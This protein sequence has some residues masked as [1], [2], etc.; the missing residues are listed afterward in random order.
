MNKLA[1][2]PTVNYI[3]L[4]E[5][6]DRRKKLESHFNQYDIKYV[7]H[8]FDRVENLEKYNF[9]HTFPNMVEP[10]FIS[11]FTVLR[12]W[13]FN[14]EDEYTVI[15]EDDL[16]LDSVRYWNF[17]W[18][19]FVE[20]LPSNWQCLQMV[21]LRHAHKWETPYNYKFT[22]REP[23][24]RGH[25][26][27]CAYLIKREYVE[28]LI[29]K[30][31]QYPHKFTLELDIPLE[32]DLEQVLFF[33]IHRRVYVFPLFVEDCYGLNTT[34]KSK[35]DDFQFYSHD[36]VMNWWKTVGCKLSLDQIFS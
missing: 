20:R 16:S 9:S 3:S 11:H 18:N 4:T 36:Y 13:Y 28:N 2:F 15:C 10:I 8:I 14:T 24:K 26:G 35:P 30:Y 1:G 22:P 6:V 23:Y 31:N 7:P 29:L 5:S 12:D 33:D 19:E 34:R 25:W 17:T 32:P 27:A 21:V